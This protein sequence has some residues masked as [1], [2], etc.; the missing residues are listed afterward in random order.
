MS[1]TPLL[2]LPFRTSRAAENMAIDTAMGP[3]GA[4][5]GA[6]LLRF[7]GWSGPALTF[8][9]SQHFEQ[10]A[11]FARAA[12]GFPAEGQLVRRPSGGGI[13]DHRADVTYAL[14]VPPRTPA[15]RLSPRAFY[16]DLHEAL[17]EALR[18]LGVACTL[19]PCPAPAP[20]PAPGAPAGLPAACFADQAAPSDVI[21]APSGEKIAG[22]AL[23]RSP[24]G[25][26][27]QGSLSRRTL[28]ATLDLARL[29]AR[30]ALHLG[31]AFEL[32]VTE[33][34][35]SWPD[36]LPSPLEVERFASERWNRRR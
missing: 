8:G 17:A 18:E 2:R 25:V 1:A 7:Y 22:A 9:Y 20:V 13:V 24:H 6:A 11:T 23:R 33:A 12:L 4:A 36:A 19:A 3:R 21:A 27:A 14:S 28:P 29:A 31:N 15:A 32:A 26:L 34:E 30:F 16:C 5:R 35:V 10:V